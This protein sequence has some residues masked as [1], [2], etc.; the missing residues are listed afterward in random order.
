MDRVVYIGRLKMVFVVVS[1]LAVAALAAT[2][3]LVSMLLLA[4][5]SSRTPVL[6]EWSD[7]LPP[8]GTLPLLQLTLAW[9]SLGLLV[10]AGVVWLLWVFSTTRMLRMAGVEGLQQGP[11]SAVA[12]HF[13]PV[14]AYVMPMHVMTELERATRDPVQWRALENSKLAATAWCVAKIASIVFVGGIVRHGAAENTTQYASGLW[15]CLAGAIG[16]AAGL[17]LFNRYLTHM[18]GLQERLAARAAERSPEEVP[19]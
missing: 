8:P 14:L 6:V 10:L 2:I 13:V 19:E 4:D 3:V 17:Y 1:W 11:I 15:L 16:C 5:P 12:M 18:K 9:A 7:P